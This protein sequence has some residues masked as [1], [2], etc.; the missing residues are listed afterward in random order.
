MF[1]L[2]GVCLTAKY[3]NANVQDTILQ[4]EFIGGT[5]KEYIYIYFQG[6]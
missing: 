6:A 5:H 3:E 4:E 1:Y 2:K